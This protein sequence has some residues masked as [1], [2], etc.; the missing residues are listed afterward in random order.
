MTSPKPVEKGPR[1]LTHHGERCPRSPFVALAS[2]S[3][4]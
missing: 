1:S 2:G 4:P 3:N